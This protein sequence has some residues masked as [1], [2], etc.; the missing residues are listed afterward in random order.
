M[1]LVLPFCQKDISLCGELLLWISEL[2]GCESYGCLLVCD[3]GVQFSQA[4]AIR[5][6]ALKSFKEV[7]LVGNFRSVEGW[8]SGANSLF[9]TAANMCE[10]FHQDWF[11]LEPDAWPLKK[12]WL[13]EIHKSYALCGQPF[14]GNFYL[15][16]QPQ[17]SGNVMSGVACYPWDAY[18]RLKDYHDTK[19]AFDLAIWPA[20]KDHAANTNLIQHVWGKSP[21]QPPTFVEQRNGSEGSEV[22][23]LQNLHPEAVVFHRVKNLSLV[24]LLRRKLFPNATKLLV[25][26]PFCNR[27]GALALEN[28]RWISELNRSYDYEILLSHDEVTAPKLIEAMKGAATC[29]RKV[30]ELTYPAATTGML[31]HSNAF[32]QAAWHVQDYF[33]CPF[34]WMEADAIPLKPE[35]LD[36]LWREYQRGGKHFAGPIV[37]A[38]LH[39]NGTGIYPPDAP[40]RIPKALEATH[41]AWDTAMKAEMIHDCFDLSHV[42]MHCWGS[43]GG[44]PHP[45]G[46][47]PMSFTD[48]NNLKWIPP[49]AVVWHR[50]KDASLIHR[51][52]ERR[53]QTVNV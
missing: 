46:G 3:Y 31:P 20:V 43:V 47:Q 7:T 45:F 23:T 33:R 10:G 29:F 4:L 39:M 32:K 2:G 52:R 28:M 1:L 25:V 8:E 12:G 14:M 21:T 30:H 16:D 22:G 27:D 40:D 13:T 18:S 41:D 53:N 38:M 36:V 48:A 35:W 51:L 50:C 24:T 5:D 37:P 11:W 49:N 19:I 44:R 34:L 42:W 9:W 15:C 6:L 26:F 17:W